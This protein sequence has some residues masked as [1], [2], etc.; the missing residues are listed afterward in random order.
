ME[1]VSEQS[2]TMELFVEN[3]PLRVIEM[4]GE[5]A[6]SSPHEFLITLIANNQKPINDY[7]GKQANLL[8]SQSHRVV[9]AVSG[10]ITKL[11]KEQ[12]YDEQ[13]SLILLRLESRLSLLMNNKIAR[14]FLKRSVIHIVD[15]IFASAII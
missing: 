2:I 1:Q 7:L 14:I 8:I 11:T 3:M 9:R 10:V 5:E 6:I 12:T 4:K 15:E 13:R